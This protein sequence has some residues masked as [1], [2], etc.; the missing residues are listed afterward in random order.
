MSRIR[1]IL[2]PT[3]FADASLP[4]FRYACNLARDNGARLVVLHV[5]EPIPPLM[6]HGL[7]LPTDTEHTRWTAREQLHNLRPAD[8]AVDYDRLLRDGS[9]TETIL[10]VAREVGAELIV[11]GTHGRSGLSRLLLGSVAENVLRGASC[12]VLFVKAEAV[13][14]TAEPDEMTAAG[15]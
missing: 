1:T 2:H 8:R 11:M 14:P 4:A 10:D 12:P 5:F 13:A 3:D 15:I 9:P 7:I 6:V